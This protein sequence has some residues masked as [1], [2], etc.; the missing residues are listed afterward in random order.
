MESRFVIVNCK[1]L[2]DILF[3]HPQKWG[4]IFREEPFHHMDAAFGIFQSSA[5]GSEEVKP[6]LSIVHCLVHDRINIGTVGFAEE[7]V[8]LTRVVIDKSDHVNFY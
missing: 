6:M 5:A 7:V 3:I 2:L 1:S 4:S 8:V